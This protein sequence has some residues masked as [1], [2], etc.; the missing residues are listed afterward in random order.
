MGETAS[1]QCGG[2]PGVS[3]TMIDALWYADWIGFQAKY[4]SIALVR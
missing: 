2:Q 4:G 1:G 3:D